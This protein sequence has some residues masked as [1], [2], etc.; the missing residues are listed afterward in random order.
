MQAL[1]THIA[2]QVN[3]ATSQGVAAK[4]AQRMIAR[5]ANGAASLAA[6][7]GPDRVDV[8][9]QLAAIIRSVIGADV[10]PDQPLMQA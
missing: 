2:A 6:A 9:A 10:A 4:R 1:A 7:C 8:L 3:P 5:P